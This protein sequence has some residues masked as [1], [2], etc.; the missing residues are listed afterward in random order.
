M[1][2]TDYRQQILVF[3]LGFWFLVTAL[4]MCERGAT[5]NQELTTK[6]CSF[7]Y[8]TKPMEEIP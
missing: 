4:D 7:W 8:T 1:T 5:K 6:N 3:P 2:G